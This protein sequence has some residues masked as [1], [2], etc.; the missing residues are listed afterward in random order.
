MRVAVR[1]LWTLAMAL[2]AVAVVATTALA[3]AQMYGRVAA[4]DYSYDYYLLKKAAAAATPVQVSASLGQCPEP[5][6]NQTVVYVYQGRA[7]GFAADWRRGDL[8]YYF[9]LCLSARTS[10]VTA[11]GERAYVYY[12]VVKHGLD[13]LPALNVT[14]G[15]GRK[16]TYSLVARLG[17]GGSVAASVLTVLAPGDVG[18]C[19]YDYPFGGCVWR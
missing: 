4:K 15:L 13:P 19:A 3:L 7:I 9:Y 16:V 11:R 2:I 1:G 5:G 10:A 18:F 17:Q 8:R 14:D 12:A 6:V